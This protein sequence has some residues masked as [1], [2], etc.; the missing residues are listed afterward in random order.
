MSNEL[1]AWGRFLLARTFQARY[2]QLGENERIRQLAPGE[3]YGTKYL[4]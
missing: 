3:A 4:S 2:M 1:G